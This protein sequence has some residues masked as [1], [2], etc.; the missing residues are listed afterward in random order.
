M[1]TF[2][3]KRDPPQDF[4]VVGEPTY[5]LA[6]DEDCENSFHSTADF[7]NMFL[8]YSA[9]NLSAAQCQIC[10]FDNH[11]QGPFVDLIMSSFSTN[12]PLKRV[13]AY[14]NRIVLFKRVIFH[15]ESPAALI[16]PEVANPDPLKCHS[17]SLFQAY[18]KYVLKSFNLLEVPPPPIPSV[19]LSLRKRT[20]Q[21]NVGRIMAN[22]QEVI[23]ILE[24]GNMMNYKIIDG[25]AMSFRQHIEVIVVE[26]HLRSKFADYSVNK[27]TNWGAWCWVNVYY[28][29]S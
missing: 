7:M 27:R 3:D 1:L 20:Q 12:F 26:I 5:L 18:Q 14:G 13:T 21:K 6:R 10:L 24:E 17:T 16:F 2:K 11:L 28:V 8:V 29:C 9:L 25:G 4:D 15:L 23:S 19:T 22:E